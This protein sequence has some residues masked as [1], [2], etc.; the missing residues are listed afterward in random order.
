VMADV[1]PAIAAL[2]APFGL[3]NRNRRG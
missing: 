2:G 3:Q 1:R